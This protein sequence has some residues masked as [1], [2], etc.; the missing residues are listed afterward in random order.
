MRNSC[1]KRVHDY[2]HEIRPEGG[3]PHRSDF[4]PADIKECLPFIFIIERKHQQGGG[5]PDYIFRLIGT[6]LVEFFGTDPTGRSVIEI[7]APEVVEFFKAF[8]VFVLD[9]PVGGLLNFEQSFGL[10][11]DTAMEILYL[12][13]V[14]GKEQ[15]STE[16]ILCTVGVLGEL[17]HLRD[18]G[19]RWDTPRL[20]GGGWLDL[21]SG[22]PETTLLQDACAAAGAEYKDY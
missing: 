1:V 17:V 14:L 11:K 15:G 12:P 2:W 3:L 10:E 19:G 5:E 9:H 22:K 20:T 13:M 21:G 4:S 16:L 7:L 8:Y 18:M 6:Q